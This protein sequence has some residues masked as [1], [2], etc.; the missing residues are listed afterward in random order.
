MVWGGGGFQLTRPSAVRALAHGPPLS[1]LR[2]GV[3]RARVCAMWM[4][5]G[6]RAFY[7]LLRLETVLG[8]WG[9]HVQGLPAHD[10]GGA[11]SQQRSQLR[12]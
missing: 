5:G 1:P 12:P 2:E 11:L 4:C 8:G 10:W 9:L 6:V 7:A 3:A